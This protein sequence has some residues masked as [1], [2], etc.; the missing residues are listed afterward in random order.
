[1]AVEYV[2][3]MPP[4]TLDADGLLHHLDGD[5]FRTSTYVS[6]DPVT[7]VAEVS[8][9][10][11]DGYG[12]GGCILLI[13]L[14]E[15]R[16]LVDDYKERERQQPDG[17]KTVTVVDE[18]REVGNGKQF[19]A[20]RFGTVKEA[21]QWIANREK[22][23]PEKVHRGGYG[24]NYPE[25]Q[26]VKVFRAGD[27]GKCDFCN[28]PLT[29]E[30]VDAMTNRGPW[31]NMCMHCWPINRATARLGPGLG[32]RYKRQEDGRFLKVEG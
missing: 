26:Q 3:G 15:L 27:P 7:G 5:F 28:Q 6:T 21:E 14:A 16:Q 32:Q 17:A 29:D 2:S 1:M 22:T 30:F 18:E 8:V 31:A 19:V 9:Y 20:A 13:P 25:S 24:I 4:V 23:E 12:N 11:D 10:H